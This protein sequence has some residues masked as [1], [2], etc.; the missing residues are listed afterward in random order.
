MLQKKMEHWNISTKSS[1]TPCE[2]IEIGVPSVFHV[3]IRNW[4]ME[5]RDRTA[6]L[7]FDPWGCNIILLRIRT[8]QYGTVP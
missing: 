5:H 4:N 1:R 6:G 7:G 2:S 3:E 8:V